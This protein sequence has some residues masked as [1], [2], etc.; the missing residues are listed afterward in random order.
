MDYNSCDMV[1]GSFTP[2]PVCSGF[3]GIS[4]V[5]AAAPGVDHRLCRAPEEFKGD[6]CMGHGYFVLLHLPMEDGNLLRYTVK[7]LMTETSLLF[8]A[9]I[10][11]NNPHHG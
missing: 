2:R 7:F 6:H 8:Y 10:R 4:C 9:V 5:S 1:S 11:I 3:I